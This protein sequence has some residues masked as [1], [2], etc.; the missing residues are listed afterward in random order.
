MRRKRPDPE[1]AAL[2]RL[3]PLA[4]ALPEV[5]ETTSFGHPTFRVRGKSLAVLETYRGVLSLAFKAGHDAQ[6]AFLSDARFYLTP[7]VGKHGWVSLKLEGRFDARLVRG[8]LEHAWRQAAPP[9]LLSPT[10]APRAARSE[11]SP[12]RTARARRAPAGPRAA[13]GR[14]SGGRR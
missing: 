6:P 11:S 4:L 3:R 1:Q 5:V 2:V 12:A 13:R 9:A 14:A 7:Y 8:L 10:S